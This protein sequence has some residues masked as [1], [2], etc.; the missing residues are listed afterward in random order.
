MTTDDRI[1]NNKLQNDI[2]RERA[3]ISSLSSGKIGNDKYGYLKYLKKYHLLIKEVL[4]K[5][6]III[7]DF[8]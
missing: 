2:N 3:K 5:K 1:R 8:K 4:E 6:G 7:E